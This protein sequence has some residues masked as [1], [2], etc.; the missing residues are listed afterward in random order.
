M[1]KWIV[2]AVL[3][4]GLLF[5]ETVGSLVSTEK[6]VRRY[7]GM[8]NYVG[9]VSEHVT[10]AIMR[11]LPRGSSRDDAEGYL[12]SRGIGKDGASACEAASSVGR[13][14]CRLAIDHHFWELL[15]EDYTVSFE[16]DGGGKLRN[17]SAQSLFSAPTA[18]ARS[19]ATISHPQAGR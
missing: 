8:P 11:Q 10:G 12:S 7:F 3:F 16:F 6:H 14:N 19:P 15:R 13:I 9:A 1:P 5:M 18:S 2:I 17:I 4:L